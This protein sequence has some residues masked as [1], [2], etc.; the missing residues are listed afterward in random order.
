MTLSQPLFAV[1]GYDA[2]PKMCYFTMKDDKQEMVDIANNLVVFCGRVAPKDVQ[3]RAVTYLL[4]DDIPEMLQLNGKVCYLVTRSPVNGAGDTI[5]IIRSTLPQF[6]SIRL[7]GNKVYDSFEFAVSKE[8]YLGEAISY[9]EEQT[10]YSRFWE[11]YY[12]DR[13]DVNTRIVECMVNLDGM[14]VDG[15]ALRDFYYFDD[16]YWLLNKIVDYNPQSLALTKCQFVKVKNLNTYATSSEEGDTEEAI[17]AND[18]II[19]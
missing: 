6:L 7:V 17:I 16:A 10:I 1:K 8:N 5:A 11:S 12:E 9:A 19:E 4:T 18:N 13:M 2:T 3:G 14:K 15:E